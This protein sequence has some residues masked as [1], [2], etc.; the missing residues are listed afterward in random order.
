MTAHADCVACELNQD[1]S[2]APGGRIASFDHWYLE[3]L[4]PPLPI[5]GWLIL[6][7]IRHTEGIVGLNAEESAELGGLLGRLPKVL[8]RISEAE[9]VY[10]CCFTE[11]VPH[12]HIHLIPRAPGAE[13][14]GPDM[15]RA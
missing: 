2:G 3:H 14:R 9:Q 1:P 8:K 12:L 11:L 7:T 13:V 10:V 6:K 4:I 15:R 5:A